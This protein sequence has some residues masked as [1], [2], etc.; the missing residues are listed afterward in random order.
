MG[1]TKRRNT[2]RRVTKYRVT[3]RR[4]TK[5]RATKRR[6]TKRRNTKN[7]LTNKVNDKSDI[8]KFIRKKLPGYKLIKILNSKQTGGALKDEYR[9]GKELGK[10]AYGTV[11]LAHD[12]STGKKVV[13]KEFSNVK[14]SLALDDANHEFFLSLIVKALTVN[15]TVYQQRLDDNNELNTNMIVLYTDEDTPVCD[16]YLALYKGYNE[17]R[18]Y[19]NTHKLHICNLDTNSNTCRRPGGQITIDK[20][21]GGGSHLFFLRDGVSKAA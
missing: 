10:G 7:R 18:V 20:Y 2:K 17:N 5:R 12:K 14:P 8:N 19:S 3:N 15:N 11:Y 21:R 13:I 16:N 4:D 9:K 1:R 6:N